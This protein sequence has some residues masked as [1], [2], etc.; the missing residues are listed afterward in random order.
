MAGIHQIGPGQDWCAAANALAPGD[1]LRLAPGEYVGSCTIRSGGTAGAPVVV[2]A[3]DPAAR[4]RLI[5]RGTADN[6]INVATGH[7]TLREL[8]FG[9]TPTDVDAV[10]IKAGDAVAVEDC[11]FHEVGGIAIASTTIS[12]RGLTI[13]GNEIVMSRATAIYVGCHDGSHCQATDV[14][15]EGN[16]IRGVDAPVGQIGYGIQVK[17]NSSAIIRGNVVADTKGPGIMVYGARSREVVNVVEQNLVMNSRTSAGIVVG[18]GPATVV[19]NIV[20]GG[21]AG[22]ALEDYASRA[23][24]RGVVVAHNTVYGVLG[25][26]IGTPSSGR[27][28]AELIYNA[29]HS[30]AGAALP[31]PTSGLKTYGNVDCQLSS[32]FVDPLMLNFGPRPGS[33]LPARAPVGGH[34]PAV[35]FFGFRR[36]PLAAVGAIDEDGRNGVLA[37]GKRRRPSS[38]E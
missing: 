26:G 18:G 36:P 27:L 19:N 1:E 14:V 37:P 35:D 10:R 20:V 13:T 4:P 15:I 7:V 34:T 29:S 5:A 11:E 33:L 38:I 32:C 17:L 16:Y 9:P 2:R 25:G 28:E 31:P 12:T 21:K 30:V 6:L 24:L 23:L 8:S 3:A 22:I